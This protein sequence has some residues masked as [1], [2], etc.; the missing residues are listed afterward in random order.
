MKKVFLVGGTRP[1]FIK[2]A[3]ITRSFEKYDIN[4][5]I[6]H[7]GQHYDYEMDE[8]FFKE[9]YLKKPFEYLGVGSKP[10]GEQTGEI[11]IKFE[12]V[13]MKHKPDLVLV[14][15]DVNSTVACSLV[16]VKMGIPLAHQ[17]AGCRS[18]NRKTPEEINRVVTDSIADF[19]FTSTPDDRDNLL[20]E[21][22]PSSRIFLVGDVVI[23]NLVFYLDKLDDK[24]EDKYCLVTIHR[25]YNTDNEENLR[26]IVKGLSRV[27]EIVPVVFPVHPRTK[28]MI[29]TFKLN[30]YLKNVHVCKPLGYLDFISKLKNSSVLITDS[31]GLQVESTF[32]NIPCINI[33]ES[34]SS[35]FTV[36]QGTNILVGK[37]NEDIIFNKTVEVL[38]N[39][40]R[41]R[42]NSE[43]RNLLDGNASNRISE[44]IARILS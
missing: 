23:D 13:C 16:A 44:I 5:D 25:N 32:L 34:T 22:I 41:N 31:G 38:D 11:M 3:P 42:L 10:H 7:T 20:K 15:G 35:R 14:V 30:D 36:E 33:R 17:E 43:M 39:P 21:N 26:N 6:I 1:N 8:I 4:Y 37:P 9:F 18:G 29:T 28:K 12:K 19:L 40:P 27:N 2:L 24:Y